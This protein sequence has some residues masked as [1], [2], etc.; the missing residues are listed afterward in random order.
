MAPPFLTKL[1]KSTFW[2]TGRF[3]LPCE[4]AGVDGDALGEGGQG[5]LGRTGDGMKLEPGSW[6]ALDLGDE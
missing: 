1:A 4:V 6:G 5:G 3:L 2:M